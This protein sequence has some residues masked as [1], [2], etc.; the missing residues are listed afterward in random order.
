MHSEQSRI[1][2]FTGNA[3]P[4]LAQTICNELGIS[5]GRCSVDRFSDGE[6]SVSIPETVRGNDVYL[7]QSTCPPVNENL[8]EVL[9]LIDAF[10]RASAGRINAV[11][12]YYGYARQDRKAKARDPISAKLIANL[13]QAA[14][15]DRVVAMDLHASQLQGFFDIPVDHL[16]AINLLG[17]YYKAKE[18]LNK[19][20]TIVLS[21]DIGGVKRARN[22][23]AILDV[24]IAIIEK[25]RPKAN[26]AEV[27][28]VIGEIEGKHVIIV[29]DMIDTA[30]SLVKAAE[31]AKQFG[32]LDVYASCTHGIL[33]G[34][35]IER[36]KNSPI[37]EVLIT[38]TIPLPAE[39]Q[40]D[41][42]KVMSV[43]ELLAESI[44]RI[45]GNRSIS[46]LFD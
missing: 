16:K 33:S 19:D 20:N 21:P 29:D 13:L 10:K 25:R 2:V 18:G 38:D 34:P 27:M 28:N 40:I 8:M 26:V 9:I 24:P 17:E 45:H 14:G 4:E 15:A 31:V 32:S 39:K 42:I 22:L 37:L 46:V 12:P 3:N 41:K 35:A 44:R 5:L 1:K 7:I 6:I 36:I 30:G 43:A 23:G 11:I